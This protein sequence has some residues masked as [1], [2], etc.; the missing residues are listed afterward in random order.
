MEFMSHEETPKHA[1]GRLRRTLLAAVAVG[2]VI[3]GTASVLARPTHGTSGEPVSA[4]RAHAPGS[5]LAGLSAN[6]DTDIGPGSDEA[7]LATVPAA[8]R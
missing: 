2:A 4:V 5:V 1:S 8:R 7:Q 3:L 6:A